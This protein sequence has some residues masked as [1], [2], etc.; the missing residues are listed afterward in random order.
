VAKKKPAHALVPKI[1]KDAIL[2]LNSGGLDSLVV[3]GAVYQKGY[4]RIHSLFIDYGQVAAEQ[5]RLAAAAIAAFYNAQHYEETAKLSIWKE[6]PALN[7]AQAE[8]LI[9]P[10]RNFVLFA[11]A[12]AYCDTKM[13]PSIGVGWDAIYNTKTKT[14]YSVAWDA[15]KPFLMA[16]CRS[17]DEGSRLGWVGNMNLS[18][19]TPLLNKQKEQNVKFGMD[20]SV[21]FELSWSCLDSTSEPCQLCNKCHEREEM[22]ELLGVENMFNRKEALLLAPKLKP[23]RATKPR[24]PRKK[25][26][27]DDTKE[28]SLGLDE[29]QASG[30]SSERAEEN[31]PFESQQ[32]ETI[33]GQ[34][35]G[36]GNESET[37][38]GSKEESSSESQG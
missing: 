33:Q 6:L 24:A 14:L 28:N 37:S 15:H 19:E 34:R 5:E 8:D 2:V 17:F 38:S 23:K 13:I 26:V 21:P 3:M 11:I 31:P 7:N 1:D 35:Q 12:G 27:Q 30:R 32:E 20:L 9:V 4:K 22:A 18:V 36:D 10:N 25:K 16:L 29:V